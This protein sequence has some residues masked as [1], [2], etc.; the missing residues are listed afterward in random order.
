MGIA[1]RK[2]R[3]HDRRRQ[4]I[5]SAARSVF[6]ENGYRHSTIVDIATAAELSGGTL[7]LYFKNKEELFLSLTMRMFAFMD[8]RMAHSTAQNGKLTF[9]ERLDAVCGALID[10]YE[11]DPKM[12]TFTLQMQG[13]EVFARASDNV[14]A[15][16]KR[17]YRRTI[18]SIADFIAQDIPGGDDFPRPIS[19]AKAIW[20]QFTGIVLVNETISIINKDHGKRLHQEFKALVGML[21]RGLL[22]DQPAISRTRH[23][24]AP[25]KDKRQL[26]R[27]R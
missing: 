5:L 16:L 9:E 10:S 12:M 27:V 24:S 4:Q 23:G 3:E 17:Q 1:E 13:S 7:Y 21:C 22:A 14:L 8:M 18:H 25:R 11:H 15:R 19:I 2:L 6:C 26:A 20:S